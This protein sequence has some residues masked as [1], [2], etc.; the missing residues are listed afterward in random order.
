M[1]RFNN[2][3]PDGKVTWEPPSLPAYLDDY[4]GVLP[5]QVT[6]HPKVG[7]EV[8]LYIIDR[9][10]FA[11]EIAR[12]DPFR[13]FLNT[14]MVPCP[15]GPVLFILYWLEQPSGEGPFAMFENTV[16]PNDPSQM[17]MYWDLARQTH[18]HVFVLGAGNR[19]LNWFE[20]QNNF[21]LDTTIDRMSEVIYQFPCKDF[22][23]AKG[24]FLEMYSTE[25]LFR[26][27]K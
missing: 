12:L 11:H 7:S 23:L 13:L 26:L 17:Q 18:W 9:T 19:E 16:N 4:S 22:D 5:I 27:G 20:F 14:G 1:Q 3:W 24:E 2:Q 8:A 6:L 15:S 25:E 21:E 10:P